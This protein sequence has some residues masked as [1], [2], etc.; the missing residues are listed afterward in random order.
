[1]KFGTGSNVIKDYD[2]E[3]KGNLSTVVRD[4]CR[5]FSEA[6]FKTYKSGFGQKDQNKASVKQKLQALND[7]LAQSCD[8]QSEYI[9]YLE[10]LILHK[11]N[12]EFMV[13]YYEICHKVHHDI[14][15]TIETHHDTHSFG[16]LG[17]VD[18][19]LA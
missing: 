19:I 11:G 5:D 18:E 13:P 7:T 10:F 17:T 6:V 2:K 12:W 8:E 16:L 1:M 9:N 15:A 3:Y 4:K 14:N